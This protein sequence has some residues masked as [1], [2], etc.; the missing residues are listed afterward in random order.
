MERQ[1]VLTTTAV[2]LALSLMLSACGQMD[3][4]VPGSGQDAD[5]PPTEA[6]TDEVAASEDTEEPAPDEP[7]PVDPPSDGVDVKAAC[8]NDADT[9]NGTTVRDGWPTDATT[10]PEIAGH[11]EDFLSPSGVSGKWTIT[12]DGEIV[13]AVYH[14]GVIEVQADN[15]TIRNSVICGTGNHIILNRGQNLTVENSIVRGERG[16]VSDTTTGSPCQSAVAF[17]NHTIRNSEISGCNDGV[18]VAGVTEVHD[19]WF[20]DNYSNRFGNGAGTH[21]DTVQSVNG[22][23]TRLVFQGNS[24]YQDAC[25][26]NRHFQLAP[27]ETQSPID[28]L[29]IE[30]NFFHGI[31]GINLDRGSRAVD[32]VMSGNTFAGSAAQGPFSRPLYSGDGMGSVDVSGNVYESGEAADSNPAAGYECVPG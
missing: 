28:V 31:K 9:A 23:M 18:K 11:D 30:D 5:P 26:S 8:R 22:P 10:G 2:A 32:G 17:S 4:P 3:L 7:E 6:A 1:R 13:D 21:N 20:H 16:T 24:A 14:N 19:S 12:T 25:T 15:V 27:T 29:R